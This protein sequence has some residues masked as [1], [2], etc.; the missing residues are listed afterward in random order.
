MILAWITVFTAVAC[1]RTQDRM[2]GSAIPMAKAANRWTCCVK[3]SFGDIEQLANVAEYTERS[4]KTGGEQIYFGREAENKTVESDV[5][6]AIL[7]DGFQYETIN[8]KYKA[9]QAVIKSGVRM[10]EVPPAQEE[11]IAQYACFVK[12]DESEAAYTEVRVI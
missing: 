10:C 4:V 12:Q 3:G 5:H 9:N 7:F 6:C 8:S 11:N 2:A 1:V